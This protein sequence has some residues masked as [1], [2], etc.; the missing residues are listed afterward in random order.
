LSTVTNYQHYAAHV[1]KHDKWTLVILDWEDFQQPAWAADQHQPV[2][3][4]VTKMTHLQWLITGQDGKT[5]E[6]WIDEVQL[7]EPV[8]GSN[9]RVIKSNENTLM[10]NATREKLSIFSENEIAS[11]SLINIQGITLSTQKVQGNAV[12][13]SIASLPQGVYLAKITYNE[14]KTQVVKF[15]K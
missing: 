4:D 10:L 15:V 1:D 3:F 12:T 6:I 11:I 13:V 7:N 14:S 5:G 2:D 9:N 8:Y